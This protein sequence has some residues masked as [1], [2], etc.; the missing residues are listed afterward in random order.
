MS[1]SVG[2][3][4]LSAGAPQIHAGRP[5]IAG[6]GITVGRITRWYKLGL[7]PEEIGARIGH[8]TLD[9]VAS[10]MRGDTGLAR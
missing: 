6:T 9:A 5:H 4:T 10:E 3:G 7:T 1:T 2:I 8:H